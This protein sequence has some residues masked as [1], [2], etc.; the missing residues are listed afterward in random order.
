MKKI[1]SSRKKERKKHVTSALI[2]IRIIILVTMMTSNFYFFEIK[3]RHF[4]TKKLI[5][6]ISKPDI[7]ID[8]VFLI[9]RLSGLNMFFFVK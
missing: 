3:P 5:K 8:S 4:Q 2:Y 9:K 6:M 1:L 7:K